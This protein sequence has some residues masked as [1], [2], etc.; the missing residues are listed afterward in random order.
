MCDLIKMNIG[1]RQCLSRLFTGGGCLQT[2]SFWGCPLE[3]D[4]FTL[5]ARI[6]ASDT[7]R[8]NWS[9]DLWFYVVFHSDE[10]DNGIGSK[11]WSLPYQWDG[12][13]SFGTSALPCLVFDTMIATCLSGWHLP[14][15]CCIVEQFEDMECFFSPSPFHTIFSTSQLVQLQQSLIRD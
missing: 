3:L 14:C 11:H 9:K 5:L 6:R 13:I 1:N 10:S 12:R 7:S 15:F 2:S 8:L 4:G